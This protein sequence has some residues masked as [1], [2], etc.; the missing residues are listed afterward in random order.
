MGHISGAVAGAEAQQRPLSQQHCILDRGCGS[1]LPQRPLL[2]V[3]KQNPGRTSA[4]RRKCTGDHQPNEEGDFHKR[5]RSHFSGVICIINDIALATL[6]EAENQNNLDSIWAA[7]DSSVTCEKAA[8]KYGTARSQQRQKCSKNIYSVY[9][10]ICFCAP[11]EKPQC[12][13]Y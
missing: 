6:Q 2:S 3:E 1:W 11:K 7:S 13:L 12:H 5:E 9:N 8:V 4:K 10:N